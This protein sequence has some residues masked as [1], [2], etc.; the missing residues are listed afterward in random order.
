MKVSYISRE[1]VISIPELLLE[2]L[3]S[4]WM[5][6]D[7]WVGRL[8]EGR[9][10]TTCQFRGQTDRPPTTRTASWAQQSLAAA[11]VHET[12]SGRAAYTNSP[13]HHV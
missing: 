13:S 7:V 10:G 3:H 2:L 6:C 11:R 9:N 4:L 8:D 1:G 12:G 5:E